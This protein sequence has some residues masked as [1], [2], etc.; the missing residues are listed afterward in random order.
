M[1]PVRTAFLVSLET[2]EKM[3]RL[4]EEYGINY[5]KQLDLAYKLL[6]TELERQAARKR[7]LEAEISRLEQERDR[8]AI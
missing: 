3:K 1:K 6:E 4:K 2:R 7:Q 8:L 5:T